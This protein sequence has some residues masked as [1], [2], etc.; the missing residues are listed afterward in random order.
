MWHLGQIFWRALWLHGNMQYIWEST[1]ALV[2]FV[3]CKAFLLN[4]R[5]SLVLSL[6]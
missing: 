5:L 4:P 2:Y 6:M 3:Y 1:K